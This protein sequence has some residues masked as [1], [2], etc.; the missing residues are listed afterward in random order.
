MNL[1]DKA[2]S[3]QSDHMTLWLAN[4]FLKIG[5]RAFRARVNPT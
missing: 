4:E 3:A 2:R 1:L 5:N